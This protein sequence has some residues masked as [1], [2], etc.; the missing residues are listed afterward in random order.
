MPLHTPPP[1]PSPSFWE[2]LRSWGTW[3]FGAIASLLSMGKLADVL[4]THKIKEVTAI[5]TVA[6]S[7]K[8]IEDTQE[9]MFGHF[10]SMNNKLDEVIG[11]VSYLRGVW[12]GRSHTVRPTPA[13]LADR[14]VLPVKDETDD[15]D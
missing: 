3:I 5:D 11:E 7:I 2:G 1:L 8:N 12:E 6:K 4:M 9:R 15:T 10:D 13:T 14:A